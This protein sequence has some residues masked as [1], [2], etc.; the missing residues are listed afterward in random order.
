MKRMVFETRNEATSST[1]REA[2]AVSRQV[3]DAHIEAFR[4]AFG[5]EPKANGSRTKQPQPQAAGRHMAG[6]RS[7]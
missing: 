3:I 2:F 4:V 1:E 6:G 7:R 5:E